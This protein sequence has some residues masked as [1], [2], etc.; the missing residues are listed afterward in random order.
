[1]SALQAVA[2]RRSPPHTASHWTRYGGVEAVAAV[3][4]LLTWGITLTHAFGGRAPFTLALTVA[5]T[6]PLLVVT[7]AHRRVPLPAVAALVAPGLIALAL[8]AFSATGWSGLVEASSWLLAGVLAA[9]IASYARKPTHRNLVVVVLLVVGL[10][11]LAQAWYP[12]WGGGD[13]TIGL[14]GS[15]YWLNQFAAFQGG[16]AVLGVAVAMRSSGNL[17]TFAVVSTPVI[18]AGVWLSGSRAGLAMWLLG[19][20][21]VAALGA[22]RVRQSAVVGGQVVVSFVLAWLL[23]SPA[24]M[25]AANGVTG[26][27][28]ANR[29]DAASDALHRVDFWHAALTLALRHPWLGTGFD[30]FGMAS[31]PLLPVDQE[32]SSLVHNGWLQPLVDGGLLLAVPVVLITAWPALRAL[33]R[34]RGA[35]RGGTDIATVGAAVALLMLLA[36]SL[37]D[38]D[39][40]YPSLLCLYAIVAGLLPWRLRPLANRPTGGPL[41][42]GLLA[43]A[44]V[45]A[46]TAALVAGAQACRLSPP[47]VAWQRLAMHV[48]PLD[49]MAAALPTQAQAVAVLRSA[50]TESAFDVRGAVAQTRRAAQDDPSLGQLR[51]LALIQI[52]DVS[53]GRALSDA[54]FPADPTPGTVVG[55]AEVLRATG[56]EAAA[57]ALV[58]DAL[59]TATAQHSLAAPI[60]AQ[61][62]T[63]YAPRADDFA[64]GSLAPAAGQS[65]DGE[66]AP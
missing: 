41:A 64:R 31:T 34:L 1:V 17:R 7:R 51:A 40:T 19:A 58:T 29:G 56:D 50:N 13:P 10:Q 42:A 57:V 36:H 24:L 44:V 30:S 18:A 37:F 20:A 15:F 8:N 63:Q 53:S 32:G 52:G 38:F 61:W 9:G 14:V 2:A 12:W 16:I 11:Q 28:A 6:L 59:G 43:A 26:L 3:L 60:L 48:L 46:S 47:Q 22:R 66:E 33:R 49:S 54:A 39:W 45:L 65:D 35:R 21:L 25:G 23:A 4:A 62:L 27:T 5:A 55:R